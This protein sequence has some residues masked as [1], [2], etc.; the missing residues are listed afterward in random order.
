VKIFS[1]SYG[2]SLAREI[3]KNLDVHFGEIERTI[4]PDGELRIRVLEYIAGE[5]VVLV[6]S[7]DQNPDSFYFEVYFI[8]DA[9]KRSGAGKIILVIPYL[10]YQRQDHM[11]REGEGVS[12]EVIIKTLEQVEVDVIITF[13]LHSIKIPELF[14]IPVHHLSALP[15]FVD[16]IKEIGTK[17]STL[18]SPDMGG[19]RRIKLISEMLKDLPFST[20]KK[21]RNLSTGEISSAE[22]EGNVSKKIFIVDDMISTGK[23]VIAAAQLLMDRGAREIYVFATHPIFSENAPALLSNPIIKK[24]FVTDSLELS[25]NKKFQ[26]LKILSLSHMIADEIKKI[27]K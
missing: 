15:L 24:V 1:T 23:T 10:S 27:I 13:D 19:T 9:L 18:V 6:A 4:F 22:I 8:V 21:N 7:K 25:A 16:E 20:I 17:D 3:S 11:F 5:D 12:L 26:G 2:R 14:S